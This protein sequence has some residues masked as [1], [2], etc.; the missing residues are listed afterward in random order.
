MRYGYRCPECEHKW[1]VEKSIM[2]PGPCECPSCGADKV[3]RDYDA[4]SL[5]AILY[6]NRP[7]WTY[8][9]CLKY[10]DCKHGEG[11]RTK[12][13]PS[14]HGDIGAWNSPGEVVSE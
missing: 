14:K 10:K 3:E 12:I 9:D 13:D 2:A 6:A 11:P 4:R 7:P 8:K 1:E 5:P